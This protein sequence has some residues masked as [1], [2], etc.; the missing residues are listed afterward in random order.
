MKKTFMFFAV[1]TA[2][3]SCKRQSDISPSKTTTPAK[4]GTVKTR[5]VA[6]GA[7]DLLGYGLDVTGDLLNPSSV[8]DAPIFDMKRFDTDYHSRTDVGN[9]GSGVDRYYYGSTAADYSREL[10]NSRSFDAN[11]G[12]AAKIEGAQK[13]G[14]KF[15]F[16]ASFSK[17]SSDDNK[18][19][20]SSAYSYA[21]YEAIHAVKRIRLTRD[22]TIPLLMNYLTPEFINNVATQSAEQLVARYGTHVMLDITIGGSF[23]LDYN[24]ANYN[25]TD[26]AKKTSETKIGLGISVLKV[27]G[28]N[29]NSD[30]TSTEITQATVNNT[31]RHYTATYYGG[32]NSGQSISI[33]K[34]GNASTNSNIAGWEASVTDKNS[35]LI[36]VGWAVYL[37]NFI[38]D[39]VKKAQVRA[40]IE[41]H[42]SD[43]QITVAPQQVYDFYTNTKGRHAYNLDPNMYVKYINDG[44][45]PNS[46]PFKAF[47]TPFNNAVPIYQMYNGQLNDRIL[48]PNPNPGWAGYNQDGILFY[49]YT[50]NVAG[51]VPIYSFRHTEIGLVKF[52]PTVVA[53]DHYYSPNSTPFD[54][55]WVSDGVAFYAFPN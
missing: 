17:S 36:D 34:D 12:N 15:L 16:S 38:A 51:T 8:S 44:W 50:T 53:Q 29:L 32:T 47:S 14:P 26:Y 48:W 37:D 27:I 7:W 54:S 28:V 21:S 5:A 13:D 2:L 18:T 20:F 33:D 46:L 41:K 42:I 52:K 31:T 30:K 3:W 40:V 9:T 24:G 22:A 23:R 39:P 1:A 43:R 55:N 10:S 25:Q 6:D 45:H 19:S 4:T 35:A 49:A 11:A